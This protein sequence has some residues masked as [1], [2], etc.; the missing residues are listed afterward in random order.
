[1]WRIHQNVNTQHLPIP[2]ETYSL[3]M[4]QVS[5]YNNGGKKKKKNGG[6]LVSLGEASYVQR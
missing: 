4:L 1:M 5:H 6:N 2:F 3:K